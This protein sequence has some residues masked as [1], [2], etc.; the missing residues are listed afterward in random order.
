MTRGTCGQPLRPD[1]GGGR[2]PSGGSTLK[3]P[4][5]GAGPDDQEN[6]YLRHMLHSYGIFTKFSFQFSIN[7]VLRRVQINF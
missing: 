5:C 2:E 6:R 3:W 7:Y 4:S 1:D